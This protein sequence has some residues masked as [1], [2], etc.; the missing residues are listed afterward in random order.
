MLIENFHFIERDNLCF[1][2][3]VPEC[4]QKYYNSLIG[5]IDP[6]LN[7]CSIIPFSI[8][9]TNGNNYFSLML[10]FSNCIKLMKY[11]KNLLNLEILTDE[12]YFKCIGNSSISWLIDLNLSN[13]DILDIKWQEEP[14]GTNIDIYEILKRVDN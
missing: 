9:I 12:N 5:D 1:N 2:Y 14:R 6:L 8:F 4:Y 11:I 3:K 7:K 10:A 13:Y